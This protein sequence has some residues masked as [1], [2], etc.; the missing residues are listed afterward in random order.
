MLNR[1]QFTRLRPLLR[2]QAP[3]QQAPRS[4]ENAS[5][6]VVC[7]ASG[8]G[9]TGKSIMASNLAVARSRMGERVLLV[10][11]DA[12][13]ANAHLL[14]GLAPDFDLGHVMEGRVSA[15]DALVEG[16][17]G[18]KL[19]SGGVGRDALV[20]PTRRELDRLF[21]ALR[22]MEDQFDLIIIDHGAGLGYSTVAHLAATSTLI[23][24]TNHEVTAL[25]DGYALYKRAMMVNKSM[26]VGVVINR[27]PDERL[28]QAGWDRFRT[29]SQRFLGS[30]PELIGW[31]PADPAVGHSVQQRIPVTLCDP[32]SAAARAIQKV[33]EWTPID[34]ARSTSAFY[35][36]AR[37]SLR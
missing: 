7:I 14:L 8:K 37:K 18:M 22:P 6:R 2:P 24:V 12:G 20:N 9:G 3:P 5:A 29:A 32:E 25:S 16:P 31:V 36:R 21:K 19:L 13:L 27:A 4:P 34:H 35:D 30:Q 26:R 15:R 1:F 33:A 10:D 23:L 28:A 17:L 11:F